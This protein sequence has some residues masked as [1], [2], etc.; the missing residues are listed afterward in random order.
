MK[1]V[2]VFLLI[3]LSIS[4]VA[5]DKRYDF[6][7]KDGLRFNLKDSLTLKKLLSNK[8]STESRANLHQQLKPK[9][10]ITTRLGPLYALPLDNM[11]CIMPDLL[12]YNMPN[13]ATDYLLRNPIDRGIY[14]GK[15]YKISVTRK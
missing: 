8:M 4:A 15:P 11:P 14:F 5:Q 10:L 2:F 13:G 1:P 7:A 3:S 6:K 9:Y 12:A